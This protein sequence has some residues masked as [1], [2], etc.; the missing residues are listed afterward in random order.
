MQGEQFDGKSLSYLNI[1]PDDYNPAASYP[2]VILLHGFGANMQD[3][4]GL[5]PNISSTGYVFSLS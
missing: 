1:Y 3:L 4:A 2:L 5:T